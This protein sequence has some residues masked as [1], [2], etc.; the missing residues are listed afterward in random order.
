MNA[1]GNNIPISLDLPTPLYAAGAAASQS[2]A[3]LPLAEGYTT[4]FRGLD[5][6]RQKVSLI[7]LKVSGSE[8]VTVPAGTFQTFKVEAA[9]EDGGV[10]MSIWVAKDSRKVVKGQIS[11]GPTTVAMEL[12]Q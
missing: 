12:E 5:L 3:A 11:T 9:S 10:K 6:Q 4:T 8:T 1:G 2:I 7:Q